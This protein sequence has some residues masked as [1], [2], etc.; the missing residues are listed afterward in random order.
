MGLCSIFFF[1][2][3]SLCCYECNVV[4]LSCLCCCQYLS[5]ERGRVLIAAQVCRYCRQLNFVDKK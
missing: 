5:L 2:E 3:R 1:F 4:G